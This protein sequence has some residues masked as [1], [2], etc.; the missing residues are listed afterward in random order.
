MRTVKTLIRLG[1]CPGWSESSLGAHAI[2]LVL[3]WGGSYSRTNVDITTYPYKTIKLIL[4]TLYTF[5]LSEPWFGLVLPGLSIWPFYH[6][7]VRQVSQ[8]SRIDCLKNHIYTWPL[9]TRTL[10]SAWYQKSLMSTGCFWFQILSRLMTKPTKWLCAHWRLRSAW[11]SAQSDQSLDL[12]LRCAL[13]G[14]LRSQ[15]FF[16]RTVKTLI[17]LGGC[18]GWSESSLGAHAILFVLS[19]GGSYDE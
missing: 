14:K 19:W 9:L 10:S 5:R 6:L 7:T 3:S 12:S 11:A 4:Y 16:M 8:I 1:E 2:L 13:S 15:A 17:R 18:P